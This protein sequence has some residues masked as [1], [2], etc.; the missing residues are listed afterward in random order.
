MHM[1]TRGILPS[2]QFMVIVASLLVAG[3]TVAAAQYY[4]SARNAAPAA[5][6][7]AGGDEPQEWE[8]SLADI[9]AQS[10]V[11]LPDAPDPNAVQD[12]VAKAQQGDNLTD[13]VGRG[14]LA[15]VSTAGVQGLG[16]DIPTQDSIISAASQQINASSN[17][18]TVPAIAQIDAT[19][20]TM[21]TFGNAV[22]EALN[23]H[24][25]ASMN[26]TLGILAKATDTRDPAPLKDLAPIGQE[27][28]AMARDLAAIPAPK[29]LYPLYQEVVRDYLTIAT[30]YPD[31]QQAVSDPIRGLVGIQQYE[32]EMSEIGRVF[33]N[34]AQIL[35]NG[36][37]LFTKDEP[38]SA[39]ELF[40]S[41]S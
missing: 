20:D 30:L 21:R 10:G 13:S 16:G 32:E 24:P 37:I 23:R 14:I 1:S 34:M 8:Q 6:S 41:A 18:V 4:V 12:F 33:T 35:K 29:T 7:S 9:Q 3:G 28:D 19:S 40:L 31:M 15:R 27:Y 11:D 17:T 25:K 38:G 22:I 39:W 36:G 5:L 26:D 2:A